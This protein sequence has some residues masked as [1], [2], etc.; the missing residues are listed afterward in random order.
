M[1]KKFVASG[2]FVEQVSRNEEV[3]LAIFFITAWSTRGVRNGKI[4]VGDDLAHFL[5][6]GRFSRSGGRRNNVDRAHSMFCT[7]SRA[8]SM[9]DLMDNPDSVIFK[10]SPASPDV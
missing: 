5:H 7:C 2:H 10:A 8:F 3:L 4:Q 6:Q 1:L 9:S